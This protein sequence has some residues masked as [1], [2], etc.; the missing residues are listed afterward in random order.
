MIAEAAATGT[1]AAECTVAIRITGDMGE[2]A[3]DTDAVI[4]NGI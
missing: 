1:D 2:T 3:M 4:G